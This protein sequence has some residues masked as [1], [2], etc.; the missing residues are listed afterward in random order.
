[1]YEFDLLADFVRGIH[2]LDNFLSN[3]INGLERRFDMIGTC[4]QEDKGMKYTGRIW[5]VS[6]LSRDLFICHRL[7]GKIPI[8][9]SSCCVFK[10]VRFLLMFLI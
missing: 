9:V 10:T 5:K 4:K 8:G 2:E 1:M 6:D 3:K 7:G